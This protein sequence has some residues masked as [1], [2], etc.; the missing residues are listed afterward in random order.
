MFSLLFSIFF[1]TSFLLIFLI[2]FLPGIFITYPSSPELVSDFSSKV[3]NVHKNRMSIELL[4]CQTLID[5]GLG[6]FPNKPLLGMIVCFPIIRWR[7]KEEKRQI[8]RVPSGIG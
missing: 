5:N 3:F 1:S 2:E 8:L 6:D 7:F 4:H